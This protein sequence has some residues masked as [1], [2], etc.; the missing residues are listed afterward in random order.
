MDEEDIETVEADGEGLHRRIRP[1]SEILKHSKDKIDKKSR[2][3]KRKVLV[4]KVK[5]PMEKEQRQAVIKAVEELLDD[6][7][8]DMDEEEIEGA[9][10]KK[11]VRHSQ[12]VKKKVRPPGQIKKKRTPKQKQA[13]NK[14]RKKAHTP[15]AKMARKKSRKIGRQRGI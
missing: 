1:I 8:E 13:L 3:T 5:N 12:V 9:P 6:D 4:E 11:V 7:M 10:F 15:A 2:K 14:A